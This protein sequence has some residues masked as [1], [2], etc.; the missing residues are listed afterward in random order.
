MLWRDILQSR[1]DPKAGFGEYLLSE[2]LARFREE[3]WWVPD[4]NDPTAKDATA[5]ALH[6]STGRASITPEMDNSRQSSP[7]LKR[8]L[9]DRE[10][11]V[12]AEDSAELAKKGLWALPQHEAV[13]GHETA[14][15]TDIGG[16]AAKSLRGKS[17]GVVRALKALFG[18]WQR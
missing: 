3:L 12:A 11:L 6:H 15:A 17:A 5:P 7:A 9:E 1:V 8:F 18:R 13:D 14:G 16:S 2:G 10:R 4:Y